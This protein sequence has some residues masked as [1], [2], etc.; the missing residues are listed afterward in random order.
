MT[1]IYLI[2]HAEAEGN[3]YRRIHGQYDGRITPRGYKQIEYLA[4]RFKDVPIDALY[5][6]DLRRT[7]VT[8]T[9]ITKYHALPVCLEPRLREQGM[10]VWED[11]PWG[12]VYRDDPETIANFAVNPKCFFVPGSEDYYVLQARVTAAI[13]EIAE[14]NDGKTVAVVS[15]GMAIRSFLTG[16]LG[17]PSERICEVQH[18]DNTCVAKLRYKDGSFSIDYYN[19]NSHVP[20]Q[21]STFATQG[22]WKN[23]NMTTADTTNLLFE[24]M[25]LT[26]DAE[27]YRQCYRDG[28]I[29]AHGSDRGYVDEPYLRNARAI[30]ARDPRCLMKTYSGDKFAGIIELDPDRMANEGAGWVSF[31]YIVPELRGQDFGVQ[32]LGHAVSYFRGQGRQSLRLH[33]SEK[34]ERAISFYQKYAFREIGG[35]QGVVCWLKLMEKDL[36]Q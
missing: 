14:K 12:N 19:D 21:L 35:E 22:W 16:V 10:G 26:K 13:T 32:L 27:L 3:V 6:S 15:H 5:A 18:G 1:T 4:E 17:L 25:D 29:A 23:K 8:A 30:S 31:C 11:L 2:R 28:W 36:E 7:R 33:V 34:N 20:Q 24:P 9:A